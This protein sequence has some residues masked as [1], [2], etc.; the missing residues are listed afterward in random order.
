MLSIC[1]PKLQSTENVLELH[2][3]QGLTELPFVQRPAC[4]SENVTAGIFLLQ[5]VQRHIFSE[6]SRR[7]NG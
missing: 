7:C 5:V 6:R 3:G 1:I 2:H 4:D